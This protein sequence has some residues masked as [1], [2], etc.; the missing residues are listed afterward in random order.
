MFLHAT[1]RHARRR[2]KVFGDG[3]PRPMSRNV[4]MRIM[5]LARV[6]MRP[7][8]PGKHYGAI[9]AKHLAV[10]QAL[11][12]GFHNAVTG[13]CFPSYKAIADKA[14]CARST[15]AEAIK[16]L[17]DAGLL[18]WVHRLKRVHERVVN[19]FGEGVH[20]Q[21]SR[22]ERTSNG[23]QFAAPPDVQSSKSENKSGTAGQELFSSLATTVPAPK[24]VDSALDAALTRLGSAI[25]TGASRAGHHF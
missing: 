3:K 2:E 4:K 12:W 25:R 17:E 14:D 5:A 20:G 11:L 15:V 18:T 6:L 7:T 10:L 1:N 22:V 8:E 16:A 23:Y 13:L 19:L 9:T 24:P 21:R